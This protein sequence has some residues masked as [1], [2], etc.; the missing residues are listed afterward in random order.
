MEFEIGGNPLSPGRMTECQQRQVSTASG[1][2]EETLSLLQ[3]QHG[4]KKT[5]NNDRGKS[6]VTA[7]EMTDK[8]PGQ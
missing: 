2:P 4:A 3:T 5:Q 1:C 7:A 6:I 8:G